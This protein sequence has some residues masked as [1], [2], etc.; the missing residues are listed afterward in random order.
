MSIEMLFGV[1]SCVQFFVTVSVVFLLIRNHPNLEQ[2]TDRAE[3]AA[4]RAVKPFKQDLLSLEATWHDEYEKFRLI[5]ARI[6]QRLKKEERQKQ[7]A[8]D[9]DE[10]AE[11][12]ANAKPVDGVTKPADDMSKA[13]LRDELHKQYRQTGLLR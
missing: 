3:K 8:S 13:E 6:A 11:L 9:E 12:L 1:V 2:V 5:D 4:E 10:I 7:K